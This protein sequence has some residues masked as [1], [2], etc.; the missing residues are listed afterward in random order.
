MNTIKLNQ[1]LLFC[2]FQSRIQVNPFFAIWCNWITKYCIFFPGTFIVHKCPFL[3]SLTNNDFFPAF[4]WEREREGDR[5]HHDVG[6]HPW[7]VCTLHQG[8]SDLEDAPHQGGGEGR[9]HVEGKP[10]RTSAENGIEDIDTTT[11]V[12]R[13]AIPRGKFVPWILPR[14][15]TLQN[16]SCPKK[17]ESAWFCDEITLAWYLAC[18]VV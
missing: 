10:T 5:L 6:S 13:W 2:N 12:C 15:V 1:I 11:S 14:I 9:L 16:M 18:S 7:D 4:N 17:G 3:R 8:T